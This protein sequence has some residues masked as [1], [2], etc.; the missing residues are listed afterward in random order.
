MESFSYTDINL[1]EL[2][3]NNFNDNLQNHLTKKSNISFFDT[4]FWFSDHINLINNQNS[5]S[6]L[7]FSN[8]RNNRGSFLY[9]VL[10]NHGDYLV[11]NNPNILDLKKNDLIY[12]GEK[13]NNLNSSKLEELRRFNLMYLRV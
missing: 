13:F 2:P 12:L 10:N 9:Y 5:Y 1:S 11:N 3:F 6:Q 8:Y 7:W 4:N